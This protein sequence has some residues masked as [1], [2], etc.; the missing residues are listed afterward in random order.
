[1]N[2][3]K[4]FEELFGMNSKRIHTE[5]TLLKIF[6]QIDWSE[7]EYK[8]CGFYINNKTSNCVEFKLSEHAK[9]DT[10]IPKLLEI[11]NIIINEMPDLVEESRNIFYR[12][13]SRLSSDTILKYD[14]K[15]KYG[16]Y[17]YIDSCAVYITI[18]SDG[19]A[20]L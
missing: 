20:K 10:D 11:R 2:G 3:N 5:E 17:F 19:L 18:T 9:F 8:K 6:R 12:Y 4:L 14:L 1:M 13:L 16:I 15:K 7:Y